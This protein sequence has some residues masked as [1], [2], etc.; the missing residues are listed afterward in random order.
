MTEHST[1]PNYDASAPNIDEIA[2]QLCPVC[3]SNESRPYAQGFDYEM[4][5]CSNLWKFEQCTSC[6][7]VWL[8]P[9]PAPSTLGTI[10]PPSYYSYDFEKRINP[11][12]VKAKHILDNGKINSIIKHLAK[13]PESY[14]DVGCGSGRFLRLFDRKGMRQSRIYGLE[15]TEKPVK[16]LQKE[17][18]Q[19]FEKRV[20]DFNDMPHDSID[21]VTMFHVI[22]HV[23]DPGTVVRQIRNWLSPGG[24]FAIETPNIDSID[25]RIFRKS[26][27]GGYH[28]PRHWTL[29]NRK[30]LQKLVEDSG[31]EVVHIG[32]QTGHSFWMYS[33]HHW[34]R[35]NSKYPCSQRVANIFHPHKGV[36]F[37]AS[38]TLFDIIRRTLGF[39][40][41]SILLIARKPAGDPTIYF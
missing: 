10:Y 4:Q 40:T 28:I 32:Y 1:P 30:S 8:N 36:L 26:W 38:F 25:A 29:F 37:L 13:P 12:A 24:I 11:I 21:L 34:L 3:S 14:M 5:T 17:G 39:R 6:S 31:L 41:S 16:Q 2:I 18:Y 19:A 20:E 27:W 15:L 22:E 35:Y 9:R 23:E 33:F 7:C